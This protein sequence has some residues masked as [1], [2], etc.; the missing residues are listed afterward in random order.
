[1]AMSGRLAPVPEESMDGSTAAYPPRSI[2][3]DLIRRVAVSGTQIRTTLFSHTQSGTSGY[4]YSSNSG[5]SYSYPSNNSGCSSANSALSAAASDFGTHELK[6]IA[7]QM[8]SDGYTQRMVQAFEYGGDPDGALENRFLQ[9][10][11]A[12]PDPALV[13]PNSVLESWFLELDVAWV[14]KIVE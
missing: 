11:V 5:A 12:H 1:M 6:T 7:R 14:L 4:S 10:H 8:V 3:R 9:L 13:D 2:Y